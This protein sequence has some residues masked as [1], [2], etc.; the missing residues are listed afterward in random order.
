MCVRFTLHTLFHSISIEKEFYDCIVCT[1]HREWK[2]LISATSMTDA[3]GEHGGA[4]NVRNATPFR[5]RVYVKAVKAENIHQPFARSQWRRMRALSMNV[6]HKYL[7]VIK[8]SL[9]FIVTFLTF[10]IRVH[11]F[12]LVNNNNHNKYTK[13]KDILSLLQNIRRKIQTRKK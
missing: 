1:L 4:K 3:Q 13:K 9:F 11:R 5:H 8:R 12:H 6:P 7:I 2:V 10:I